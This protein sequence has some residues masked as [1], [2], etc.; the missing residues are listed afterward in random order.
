M[1]LSGKQLDVVCL[2]TVWF[3]FFYSSI[4]NI[5]LLVCDVVFQSCLIS[6]KPIQQASWMFL[7]LYNAK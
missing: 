3:P 5:C 1:I 2:G 6:N 7:N 4:Q